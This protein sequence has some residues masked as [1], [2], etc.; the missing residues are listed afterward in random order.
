MNINDDINDCFEY[1][2]SSLIL[3]N[4]IHLLTN[5]D[6]HLKNEFAKFDESITRT[7]QT[8]EKNFEIFFSK[9]NTEH[10]KEIFQKFLT[11][12]ERLKRKVSISQSHFVD[13]EFMMKYHDNYDV[14]T[15]EELR[16]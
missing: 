1:C 12:H 8:N 14:F 4:D 3:I 13:H 5:L 11:K 6:V 16:E 2:E 7:M 9:L 10:S 15:D